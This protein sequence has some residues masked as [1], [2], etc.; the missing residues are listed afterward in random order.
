M[1]YF[2]LLVQDTF[3][4]Y[5]L[6]QLGLDRLWD[7]VKDNNPSGELPYHNNQHLFHVARIAN[8]LLNA[9]TTPTVRDEIVLIVACLFHDFNHSGGVQPDSENIHNAIMALDQFA[10]TDIGLQVLKNHGMLQQ[11]KELIKLTQFPSERNPDT[12]MGLC[13]RDADMLYSFC[14]VGIDAVVTGLRKEMAVTTGVL[15]PPLD[16]MEQQRK[17]INSLTMF[18]G[19]GQY[20]YQKVKTIALDEQIRAINHIYGIVREPYIYPEGLD[21]VPHQSD[22]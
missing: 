7:W 20:L 9:E 15:T 13:I 1:T 6:Q 17:F 19:A 3:F 11:V 12:L 22:T 16:Y 2:D 21:H 5:R 8:Q 4:E 10:F 14:S 18:T